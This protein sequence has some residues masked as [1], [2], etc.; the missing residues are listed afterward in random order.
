MDIYRMLYLMQFILIFFYLRRS[1]WGK[2]DDRNLI[3][4]HP[5][6]SEAEFRSESVLSVKVF[7]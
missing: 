7:L 6:M 5:K 4:S 2:A 3:Y 1:H